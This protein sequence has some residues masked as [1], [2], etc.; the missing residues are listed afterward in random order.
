MQSYKA[1]EDG[2]MIEEPEPGLVSVVI[3]CYN[4]GRF[5]GEAIDSVRFQTWSPIEIIVVDDGSTD[6]TREVAGAYP[7]VR[8]VYQENQGLSAARNTGAAHSTGEFVVFLDA[9]DWLFPDAI[10]YNVGELTENPD[11]VFVSGGYRM[12]DRNNTILYAVETPIEGEHYLRMLES[13]YIGMHATVMYRR[14]LFDTFRY[15]PSLRSCEDYDIYLQ[16]TRNYPVIHHTHQ[17][18][19]YRLHTSNMSANTP[20]MLEMAK[21]ALTRQEKDLKSEAER[22]AYK[23]GHK[24]WSDYFGWELLKRLRYDS[25]SPRMIPREVARKT[26]KKHQPFLYYRY[27]GMRELI[28][29][30]KKVVPTFGQRWL[31]Q[32]K[33][34][35][36]FIPAVGK[37]ATG[38]FR[39][40][41]PFSTEFGYDRG[42]PVDRYYIENFLRRHADLIKGR[43][44]EIGDNSYTMQFGGDRVEKSDVLHVHSENPLATFVG[45]LSDAPQIPDNLFD[46]IILTQTLHLIYNMKG[47]VDTCMRILKPGGVL[48]LTVPGISHIDHDEWNE[49]W[50][51]SFTSG[52][53]QRL[54]S[55]VFPKNQIEIKTHGNVF[56]ATAF[57][58]GMGVS[59]VTKYELD[60]TDP[61]YQVIITAKVVKPQ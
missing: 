56:I 9:D 18:A 34:F 1:K 30:V 10:E 15:D 21:K 51:W 22:K 35:P 54:L 42:G 14:W 26:L 39:R 61:H 5:L 45:D 37:V 20:V 6:H 57:L 50:L 52:S 2:R 7:E 28:N 38:D 13:N 43:V 55:E 53:L 8:Y 23:K 29:I 27:R 31:H 12:V 40:V 46:C 3:T 58:Y 32:A 36:S 4:H 25:D 60:W 19:A 11:A 47:A 48:L 44:L 49:N 24:F 17:L 33:F 59:E 16:I 41:R